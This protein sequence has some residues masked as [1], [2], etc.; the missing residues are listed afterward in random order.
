MEQIQQFRMKARISAGD[1][2][3]IGSQCQRVPLPVRDNATGFLDQGRQR[4]EIV[5]LQTR[6]D[7]GVNQT[8]G[9]LRVGIAIATIDHVPGRRRR[10]LPAFCAGEIEQVGGGCADGG[11]R[12]RRTFADADRIAVQR[13]TVAAETDPA[14]A[15]DRLIDDA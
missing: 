12:Q 7:D 4:R 9:D 2:S 5:C 1:D 11:V 13:G 10:L 15:A 3:A 6:L 14:L 8:G